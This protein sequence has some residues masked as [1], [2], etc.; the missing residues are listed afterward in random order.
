MREKKTRVRRMMMKIIEI[1]TVG[2]KEKVG[3]ITIYYS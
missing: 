3:L 2:K 1:D